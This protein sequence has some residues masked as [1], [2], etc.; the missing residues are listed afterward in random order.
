VRVLDNWVE[1]G[2]FSPHANGHSS[3]ADVRV[4]LQRE[5]PESVLSL[6]EQEYEQLT[7]FECSVIEA[8]SVAGHQFSAASV[9]AALS[10]ELLAVEDVCV[11]WAKH[12]QFF[13]LAGKESWPDGTLSTRLA[14]LHGLYRDTAYSRLGAARQTLLHLGIA[15]GKER[16]YREHSVEIATELAHHFE[17]GRDYRRAAL[18]LCTAG[19]RAL[20]T[21]AFA[22]AGN[23]FEKG[24]AL[25]E[26][27]P[28][29]VHRA[30]LEI[31]LQV[32]AAALLSATRAQGREKGRAAATATAIGRRFLAAANAREDEGAALRATL[33]LGMAEACLG[34]L[35]SARS[36]LEYAMGRH[37][38]QSKRSLE[39]GSMLEAESRLEPVPSALA[40]PYA[41]SSTRA[42]SP[43]MARGEAGEGAI[44][45]STKLVHSHG[46]VLAL[47]WRAMLR[48]FLGETAA[49]D[50][51][52]AFPTGSDETFEPWIARV[53]SLEN[54]TPSPPAVS[55]RTRRE[56]TVDPEPNVAMHWVEGLLREAL[57]E[58]DT[59]FGDSATVQN[60]FDDLEP[61]HGYWFEL[62]AA[63]GS[64]W[65]SSVLP[66]D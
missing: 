3:L 48:S 66:R 15:R 25:I 13:Q 27:L 63:E 33:L 31:R 8:A 56:G 4:E 17:R 19:E 24:L 7:E 28:H 41:A 60:D 49:N 16:A 55:G 52:V 22:E 10:A 21:S 32:G 37:P 5:T 39:A 1:R 64:R 53:E 14:F 46:A 12:G 18:H 6:I 2:L 38:V 50:R 65:G 61:R 59:W 26:H 58:V 62:R 47:T 57:A 45:L 36:R 29:G 9:A 43:G 44:A 30:R 11:R 40:V 35:P 42:L 23:F 34:D 20:A 51:D 54:A